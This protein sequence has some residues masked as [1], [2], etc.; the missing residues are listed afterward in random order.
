MSGTVV[1]VVYATAALDVRHVPPDVDVIV[2]HNDDR[3][4][5]ASLGQRAV[6]HVETGANVGFGAAVNRALPHVSTSR[7]VLCNPDVV[8][9]PAHWDALLAAGAEEVVTVPLVDGSGAPT[10]VCSPYPTPASHLASGFR[11]GRWLPRGGRA[12]TAVDARVAS[13]AA[14][15]AWPL[16]DRWVSG[17]VL[18]VD[19]E[20]LRAV[21]G[22]DEGYFLYYEDV[23]LSRRLATRFPTMRARVADVT[24]GV[25]AVGA[26]DA[27]GGAQRGDAERARL[28]SAIRWAE[29][30][31][32]AA[33]ALTARLLAA[34]RRALR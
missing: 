23:D 8:L 2:V 4:D 3:L 30:E 15:G 9:G 16:T 20:R 11:L 7:I 26:S 6:Q 24:P 17:A 25:H 32:G 10:I 27:A 21:G 34:H 18:S 22:F 31:P 19:A 33:W 12:R 28:D 1:F 13:S 29:A 14:T 5:R